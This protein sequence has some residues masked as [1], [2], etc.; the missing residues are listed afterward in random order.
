[1]TGPGAMA[2][3]F[4]PAF[5]VNINGSS[6]A[7]DVSKNITDVSVTLELDTS[8]HFSLTVAN[9]YPQMP[10]THG[11]HLDLFKEGN[12]IKVEMG[13]VDELKLMLDGEITRISPTF[14]ESGSPT[15]R[16][17]GHNL[18]HRLQGSRKTRTFKDMTDKQIVERIAQDVNLTPEV[19]A[20]D[21]K[22]PYVI[23]YSQTDLSFIK[24][25]AKSIHF[26]V[27]VEG[28]TLKFRKSQAGM[29]KTYTL[30]WG[31]PSKSF[32]PTTQV[33]PLR[34]FTPTLNTQEQ[35]SEV[36]VRGYSVK[37]KKEIT[38]RAG[39][40]DEET[41]MGGS[42]T[43]SQ[44]TSNA[45]G[46]QRR[47]EQVSEPVASQEEADQRARALYNLRAQE[48]VTGSGATIG[49]PDL[50]AG[51]VVQIEGIGKRF[52][53]PYYL[54]QVVHTISS[55]GYLTTFIAKRDSVS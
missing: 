54:K 50:R 26:E 29:T 9:P 15:L 48:L 5:K 47:E 33:L 32:D 25:R 41:Q 10:W 6:L 23:Q 27:L 55:G 13:Y 45:F 24:E 2:S 53:G 16:V 17:E 49:I 52:S 34:S 36:I 18:L 7:A 39:T 11:D 30:V 28:T 8:D 40:G 1:M 12:S 21:T 42:Q 44:V 19:D 46:T 35:V 37:D 4:A 14:P 31:N 51:L 20:T 22:H 38:G 3:F 43:G